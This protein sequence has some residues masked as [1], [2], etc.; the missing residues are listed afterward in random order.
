[1]DCTQNIPPPSHI[2]RHEPAQISHMII[3]IFIYGTYKI[4]L[5]VE[6][7]NRCNFEKLIEKKIGTKII[8]KLLKKIVTI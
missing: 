1:M 7:N 8:I 3:I 4:V 6:F 2:H 5:A